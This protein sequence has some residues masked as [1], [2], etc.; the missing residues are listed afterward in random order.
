MLK[1]VGIHL[2]TNL[3]AIMPFARKPLSNKQKFLIQKFPRRARGEGDDDMPPRHARASSR[4]SDASL[5]S[6]PA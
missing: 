2:R 5:T 6:I 3:G 4:M 1:D